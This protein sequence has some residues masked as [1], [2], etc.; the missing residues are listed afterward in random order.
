MIITKFL[1]VWNRF[2]FQLWCDQEEIYQEDLEEEFDEEEITDTSNQSKST[3]KQRPVSSRRAQ[4]SR[5]TTARR[6]QSRP[7]TAKGSQS[8]RPPRPLSPRPP[9]SKRPLSPRRPH[10]TKADNSR[11]EESR[12]QEIREERDDD[13][14]KIGDSSQKTKIMQEICSKY[15]VRITS[16]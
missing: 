16:F 2:L 13:E 5:P 12:V 4:S 11:S 6:I 9:S 14:E 15:G 1:C 7:T 3:T 8:S 10:T